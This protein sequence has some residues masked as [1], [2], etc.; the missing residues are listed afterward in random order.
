MPFLTY[1]DAAS[2]DPVDLVNRKGEVDW[3][4][5]SLD[6]F[7]KAQDKSR[8]RAVAILGERGIGKSIVMKTVIDGLR[9]LHAATT[10]M[11]VVDCRGVG[12][13]RGVYHEIAKQ[14]VDQLGPRDDQPALDTARLLETIS[15]QDEVEH[16]TL[17]ERTTQ[18]KAALSLTGERTL[19]RL[20]GLTYDINIERSA[21]SRSTLEGTIKFDGARLRQAMLALF[22]DLRVHA[23]L[24]VIVAL[25][26]LDELRHDSLIDANLRPWIASEVDGLLGLVDGP[27]GFVVTARTYFVGSL[28]RQIDNT[29]VL[30]PLAKNE[31]V[32]V[33]NKRLR[34]ESPDT[35]KAFDEPASVECIDTLSE[36]AKT[37]LAL[38]SWFRYLAENEL[39]REDDPRQQLR[40]LLRDRFANIREQVLDAVVAAFEGDPYEPVAAEALLRA[41]RNKQAIFNQLLRSQIVLP[42]D[43]WDPY[44]FTLAPELHFMCVAPST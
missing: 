20:L 25:D 40:K 7:L 43:F 36:L 30:G 13:Q 4:R 14:L 28:S 11:V 10:L 31:H 8:G 41:C 24:D 34:N 16:R 1:L 6:S 15:A 39:F 17:A 44:E 37:P 27:I 5:A 9:E 2:I 42:V 29:R 32:E 21:R 19:L 23:K 3:L 12:S 18:F 38:L 22:H 26:N 33:I 35:Q